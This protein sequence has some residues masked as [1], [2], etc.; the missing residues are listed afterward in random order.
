MLND[1]DTI[2]KAVPGAHRLIHEGDDRYRAEMSVGMGFIRGRFSGALQITDKVEP[3]SYRLHVEGSG[4]VGSIK[5]SG[6]LRLTE[7][8]PDICLVTVSGDATVSGL[9]A[10]AGERTLRNAANSMIK[11]FFENLERQ[12]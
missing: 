8:T 11:K 7:V 3:E 12:V 10:R 5:G 1:P 2:A 4:G 9:I 6:V